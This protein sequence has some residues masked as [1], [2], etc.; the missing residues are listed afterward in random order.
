VADGLCVVLL[1][2][3]IIKILGT[4]YPMANFSVVANYKRVP[5]TISVFF[6]SRFPWQFIFMWLVFGFWNFS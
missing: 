3:N 6:N 2:E 1:Y 5:T 4:V